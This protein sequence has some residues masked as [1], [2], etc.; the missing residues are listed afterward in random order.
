MPNM[1]RH[2]GNHTRESREMKKVHGIKVD[3]ITYKEP[4]NGLPKWIKEAASTRGYGDSLDSITLY[5]T[6]ADI[7]EAFA[8]A[9]Q[10]N[11]SKCVMAQ[12]GRRLGAQAVYFYRTTAWVDFGSGPILRFET[13]KS[14]YK[15]VIEPF[16]RGDLDSVVSGLYPLIAPR[17]SAS[18][19]HRREYEKTERKSTGSKPRVVAHTDRVVL[20]SQ[21]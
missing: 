20:A 2:W 1:S 18:L 3:E 7:T 4:G 21:V 15:N 12:A 19:K 9:A 11:G 5:V 16:D 14:I 10:G 8:C 17:K 13:S 6:E